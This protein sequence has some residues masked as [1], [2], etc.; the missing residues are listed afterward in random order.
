MKKITLVFLGT[1]ILTI[2]GVYFIFWPKARFNLVAE[3]TGGFPYQIGLTG[4]TV[5]QCQPSCCSPA[6]CR[7]CVGGTLCSTILT[8][9]QC[10]IHSEVAGTPS[11]GMG[12][13]GL[14][15]NNNLAIAGVVNGQQLIAGGMSAPLM[16]SGVLVGNSGCVGVA[17]TAINDKNIFEKYYEI[18]KYGIASIRK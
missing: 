6:G 12:N 11:G 18:I 8:E 7:C 14:F 4:V 5:N 17:C 2:V 10:I 13:I 9:P 1:F 16:D 3:A 15:L